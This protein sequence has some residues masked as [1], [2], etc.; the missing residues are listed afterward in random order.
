MSESRQNNRL[1][2][3]SSPYLLQHAFNPVDWYPWSE[4]ALQKAKS[5]DKPILVSI[6]YSACHWC[7]VME[8]QSFENKEIAAIMNEHFICIKVDREE[9]PD[10]DQIYMDAIQAMGLQGG[11]PLNVFLTSGQKPFYGGTYFPPAGWSELLVNVAAAYRDQREKLEESADG[12]TKH[13]NESEV[14]KYRIGESTISADRSLFEESVTLLAQKFDEEWG[15]IQK[16]PKFPMPAIWSYLIDIHVAFKQQQA[17]DMASFTLQKIAS[18]GIFDHVG[19]GFARYSVDEEWH[20][21]HFEKMLYDNGQLLSIYAKAHVLIAGA[22]FGHTI[23]ETITWLER[24]MRSS[25]GGF[26][27]ALDADSE[28]EEG[29]YYC[30]SIEAFEEVAGD[31]AEILKDYYNIIAHGNWEDGKNNLRTLQPAS[32]FTKKY[33]LDAETFQGILEEFKIKAYRVREQR[34]RP[35]LDDKILTA[36]N[37]LTIRGLVDS[38]KALGDDRIATAAIQTGQFLID[39]LAT[40]TGQLYRNFKG[41]NASI[42]GYLEDYAWT[43]DGLIGLYEITGNMI[44]LSKARLLL[45]YAIAHFLDP[46]EG[47]FFFTDQSTDDLIAR[48]K[49]LF[50]NVIPSS[51]AGMTSCLLKLGRYFDD[52][53]YASLAENMLKG[54]SRLV[55]AEPEYLAYW[56]SVLLKAFSPVAEVVIA[57]DSEKTYPQA[58]LQ[59]SIGQALLIRSDSESQRLI[60]LTRGKNSNGEKTTYYVCFN[61]TC[62]LPVTDLNSALQQINQQHS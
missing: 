9:R 30:W 4:E 6:G 41:G 35:G 8:H 48:K 45:D 13:L 55:K 20:I 47:F 11:W 25:E 15:G 5:E 23:R 53:S 27:A 54:M 56:G 52:A 46:E 16:S 61:K 10:V 31:Y 1:I 22:D 60:P 51:N 38:Y 44:W 21:P 43:I 24:E 12:F 58:L 50:D 33:D 26:Y 29:K 49:E 19:G 14:S 59:A 18:G 62:Q 3:S 39:K 28:G 37:G 2:N 34:V 17:G 32:D 57:G 40:P 42:A 36:W 7:H